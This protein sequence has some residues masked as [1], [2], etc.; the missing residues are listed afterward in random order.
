[1]Q[2]LKK[3]IFMN[4]T[5]ILIIIYLNFTASLQKNVHHRWNSMLQEYV[6]DDGRVN[7]KGWL[8]QRDNLNAYIKTLQQFPP[9]ESDS[10][11]HKISYW[12]NTYNALTVQL[13]LKNYPVSS[14]KDIKSPW[15]I[16]NL[17]IE[18]KLYSLGDIEHKILRKMKEPRIHFAINC[19]SKSCPRL[20]NKAFQE[21]QLEQ[22]LT[23]ATE[24]FLN[25]SSKNIITP[26]HLKL[27]KIFLWF[28]KDFGSRKEKLKFI[29]RYSGIRI[30]NPKIA[31]LSYDWGLNQ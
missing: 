15:D 16:D 9:N 8:E 4:P 11:N 23:E 10:K 14:I 19:A 20:W 3:T 25:D 13:I 26:K 27:S 12:I 17:K 5:L 24:R 1:M 22:Q 6:S 31:Y 2:I 21:K 7:Y 18:E 28:G 30:E 29:E